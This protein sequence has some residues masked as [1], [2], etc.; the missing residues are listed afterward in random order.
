[1]HSTNTDRRTL[2][3]RRYVSPRQR[4]LTSDEAQTRAIS[5]MLKDPLCPSNIVDEA[6]IG[7]A[8][9]IGG[10]CNLIPAPDRNGDTA[11][12]RRLAARI[13]DRAPFAVAVYDILGRAAPVESS[14]EKHKAGLPPLSVEDHKIIRTNWKP[15]PCRQTYIVDNV[16]TNGTT[17]TACVQALGFGTGLV[18]GDAHHDTRN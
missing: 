10:N 6:A 8:A 2:A 11:A 5:Y 3:A 17:I 16:T 13:A 4:P 18:F 9:L 14:C 12:N 1:M 15:I 7:M